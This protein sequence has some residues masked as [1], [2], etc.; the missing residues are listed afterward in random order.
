MG[1][2]PLS[3]TTFHDVYNEVIADNEPLELLTK[4]MVARRLETIESWDE[5]ARP[6]ICLAC[7]RVIN[8][9]L[10]RL[11]P[12]GT[13]RPRKVIWTRHGEVCV[14]MTQYKTERYFTAVHPFKCTLGNTRQPST[15]NSKGS[16]ADFKIMPVL[17]NRDH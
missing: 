16:R 11:L 8:Y 6:L 15:S 12:L 17:D 4:E 5:Q 14:N 2:D 9:W 3:G 1:D 13:R 7:I 10:F